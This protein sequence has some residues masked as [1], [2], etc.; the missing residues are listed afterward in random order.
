MEDINKFYNVNGK[1]FGYLLVMVGCS[2]CQL[3]VLTAQSLAKRMNSAAIEINTKYRLKMDSVVID[4]LVTFMMNKSCIEFVQ[5][6]VYKG[7]ILLIPEFDD[8][9]DEVDKLWS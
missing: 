3:G 1:Y 8:I 4:K 7:D 9:I 5:E 6:N 2:K